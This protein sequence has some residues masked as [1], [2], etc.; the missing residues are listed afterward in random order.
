MTLKYDEL[1]GFKVQKQKDVY[2]CYFCECLVYSLQLPKDAEIAQALQILNM[3]RDKACIN[4]LK[5]D[6]ENNKC[7]TPEEKMQGHP[8]ALT[9]IINCYFTFKHPRNGRGDGHAGNGHTNGYTNGYTNGDKSDSNH[10]SPTKKRR[11]E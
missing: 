11:K 1:T 8:S 6:Y 2:N 3:E 5:W 10:S 4:Y 9:A 7:C